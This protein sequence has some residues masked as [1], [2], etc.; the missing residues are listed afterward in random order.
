MQNRLKSSKIRNAFVNYFEKNSHKILDSSTI[1][2][3]ND[4]SILFTNAGMVQ[5]KK[6]FTGE[7]KPK[8]KNVVTVQKCIRAGGKHND[9]DNVGFTPRHHTFFEMLG[10][11]SFGGYFKEEAIYHAWN[12]LIK[13]FGLDKSKII[14]TVYNKDNESFDI[15]KKITGFS[16]SQI[17]KISTDDNFWS[18]GDLGPCGPC[19]EIFYDNGPS[20]LGGL[21][22]TKTQDGD[23]YLEI[24]N[25]VFM[26]FEKTKS[27]LKKLPGKFVDT[28]MGLERLTAV[29]NQKVNNYE[30]DLYFN[31]INEIQDLAKI[32]VN[33]KNISSFRIIS[34]HIKSITF[35]MAEGIIPSNEGRGYV[36]RRIIRRA[37]LHCY[38]LN[39]NEIILSRLLKKVID[40][41][42]DIYLNL[43]EAFNFIQKNLQIEENKFSETLSN[44]LQLLNKEI[45][46]IKGDELSPTVAF[47][48]YD[49]YGFPFDMTKSILSEKKIYVNQISYEKIVKDSK[50]QQKEFVSNSKIQKGNEFYNKLSESVSSTEFK[51]YDNSQCKSKLIKIIVKENFENKT[52]ANDNDIGLVFEKSPF[53]AESGGQVGDSG[54]IYDKNENL[55]AHISDTKA[56]NGVYV[57]F[58][59]NLC[60]NLQC[61]REYNLIIDTSRREKIRNNHTATHL[62]HQSLRMVVGSHVSQKGSLVTEHKLRFDYTSNESLSLKKKTEVEQIVNSCIRSN[63]CSVIK[64]MSLKKAIKSGAIALFGEKYPENVRVLSIKH[65]NDKGSFESLELCGGTHVDSTGEIG[66]FKILNEFSVSSGIRRVEAITGKAAEKFVL[67]K[68]FLLDDIKQILKANDQN[69]LDKLKNLK[70]ENNNL[71]KNKTIIKDLYSD[72][73]NIQF[74]DIK[75]YYQNLDCE[76]KELKNNSDN[77]KSKINCGIII[78]TCVFEKKISIVTSITE[79]LFDRYDSNIILKKIVMFLDG[80]GGGG[81]KDLAQGG[82]PLSNKFYELKDSLKKIID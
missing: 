4:D 64:Y 57:H 52:K 44:G 58:V 75:I 42:S 35:L 32:K 24:W 11:F 37:S 48:L 30:T 51:G 8:Y 73:N 80:K 69:L 71:K 41:Y 36:L 76:P 61:G 5:F 62:L 20:L 66:Y 53:Y 1:A 77:I 79:N 27:G 33:K 13:E 55:L 34:D 26:E 81:R 63:I 50:N 82:A 3:E 45:N 56:Y 21:P 6:W 72:A 70:E 9:L 67:E 47:K 17:L 59:S 15:W 28:G 78:L 29:L 40:E 68:I 19:S 49:T 60:S 14:I 38:K 46:S 39:E 43:S 16:E 2:P 10:N 7:V 54:F 22:G 12:L 23:R 65:N 74:G 18:M 31:L 25:L